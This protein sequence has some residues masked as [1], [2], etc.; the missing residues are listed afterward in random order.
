MSIRVFAPATV[1]N[2]ACGYDVLGLALGQPGDEVIIKKSDKAGVRITE[3]TG[4]DGRLPTDP[5]KN[6]VGISVIKYLE[7]IGAKEQGL[8]ITLHKKMPF[9]SG[10]GSSAASTVA[11]VFAANELL[12]KP[13]TQENLL[14]FAMEGERVACGS[15]HADNVAPALYGGIVLIRSYKPLD[16]IKLP[17]PSELYVTVVHPHI[18]VATKDARQ[19][20]KSNISFQR[21]IEQWGNVGGLVAGLYQEDYDL[22]SRSLKD[23]VVEPVRSILI[24]GFES[25]KQAAL[26]NGALGGSISGSGPSI[27]SLCKGEEIAGQVAEAKRKAFSEIGIHCDVYVSPVNQAGP[28]VLD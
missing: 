15:A 4:D 26:D 20:L 3:I 19:I 18:E 8:E 2:V 23:V 21:A 5:L 13:L 14:P 10:L 25:V 7:A 1:A 11:G 27:F 22:I 28:I 6:T 17:V 16:V 9:G 12:G 24:P